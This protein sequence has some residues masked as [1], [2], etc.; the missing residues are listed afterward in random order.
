MAKK[1]EFINKKNVSSIWTLETLIALLLAVLIL[2][3]IKIEK[4]I[5]DLINTPIGIISSLLFTIILFIFLHP[6]I[7]LL[8]IIYL[9]E[10]IIKTKTTNG[11]NKKNDTL[12]LLNHDLQETQ[13]EEEVI[14]KKAP[15]IN[16]NKNNNVSYKPYLEKD[17][18][19][20]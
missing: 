10:T 5:R 14:D 3:D 15:I 12:N 8:F 17:Y 9:Y 18:S 1:I 20:F 7:G 2:F 4:P 13:V 6:V 16:K 11:Q 19:I